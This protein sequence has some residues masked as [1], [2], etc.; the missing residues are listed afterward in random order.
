[1]VE[2]GVKPG[3]RGTLGNRDFGLQQ[4]LEPSFP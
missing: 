1:M 3:R 4:L 2:A